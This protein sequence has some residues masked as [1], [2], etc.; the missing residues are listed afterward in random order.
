PDAVRTTVRRRRIVQ[1]SVLSALTLLVLAVPVTVYT[2]TAHRSKAPPSGPVSSGS[3]SPTDGTTSSPEPTATPSA[4]PSTSTAGALTVHQL[5]RGKVTLPKWSTGNIG[6]YCPSGSVRLVAGQGTLNHASNTA[7]N[8]DLLF[9]V[10][11]T[12]LDGDPS[13]ETAALI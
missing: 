4:A 5:L 8:V 10:V 13:L 9:Q 3:P 2:A 12:N 11:H 6:S 7:S 1:A